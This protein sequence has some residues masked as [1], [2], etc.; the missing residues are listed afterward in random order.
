MNKSDVG[1]FLVLATGGGAVVTLTFFTL[2][3]LA[4]DG[5]ITLNFR[6]WYHGWAEAIPLLAVAFFYHWALLR[7]FTIPRIANNKE[8][9]CSNCQGR[10]ISLGQPCTACCG[11]YTP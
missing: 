1:Q 10:G 5:T 8:R 9:V 7:K 3:A 11:P 2:I 4:G 6:W